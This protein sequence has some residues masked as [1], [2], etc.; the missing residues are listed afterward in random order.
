MKT[1]TKN[2]SFPESLMGISQFSL[3]KKYPESDYTVM[4]QLSRTASTQSS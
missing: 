3:V 2:A 4:K 1:L